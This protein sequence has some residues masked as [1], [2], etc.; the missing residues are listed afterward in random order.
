M[1]KNNYY[2]AG[3]VALSLNIGEFVGEGFEPQTEELF[4]EMFDFVMEKLGHTYD[5]NKLDASTAYYLEDSV[6]EREDVY[7]CPEYCFEIPTEVLKAFR[8]K[9]C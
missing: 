7:S 9:F 2:E 6:E 3:F 1:K 4:N 5:S 8:E